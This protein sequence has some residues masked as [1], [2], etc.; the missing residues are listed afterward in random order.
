MRDWKDR[1]GI[2]ASVA[3]AIHC[4]VTP[5]LIAVLPTLKFTE[6]MADVRFHQAVALI[7]SALVAIS[8][9]PAFRRYRDYRILSLSTSGLGLIIAAAFLMPHTCCSLNPTDT[10]L[11]DTT[12]HSVTIDPH[13]GHSHA[14]HSHA[15]HLHAGHSHASHADGSGTLAAVGQSSGVSS[16]DDTSAASAPVLAGVGVLQP[17]MTPLG[18]LLL[19]MA[20]TLNLR[21]R[22]RCQ[23]ACCAGNHATETRLLV[24][25][26]EPSQSARSLARAS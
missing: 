26:S 12:V 6:W 22:F 23:S 7:C 18:G 1:L 8:I 14:G 9:W 4:A 21:R 20:H 11:T 17:W 5:V 24:L 19:I 2:V 16:H 25:P 15:A 13:A 3:C 10:N